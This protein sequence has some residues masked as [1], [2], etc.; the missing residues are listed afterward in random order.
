M[1]RGLT[2]NGNLVAIEVLPQKLIENSEPIPD[3]IGEVSFQ[4]SL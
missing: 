4:R 2:N 3:K 1:G